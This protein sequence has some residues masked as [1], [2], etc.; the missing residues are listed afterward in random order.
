MYCYAPSGHPIPN[1][2]LFLVWFFQRKQV[3]F[4][5]TKIWMRTKWYWMWKRKAISMHN[6]RGCCSQR[7]RERKRHSQIQFCCCLC[8]LSRHPIVVATCVDADVQFSLLLSSLF[9]VLSAAV[10]GLKTENLFYQWDTFSEGV[11]RKSQCG[12]CITSFYFYFCLTETRN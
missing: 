1:L 11:H 4:E 7:W 6:G 3:I 9:V 12:L 2:L 8:F 10:F 5:P